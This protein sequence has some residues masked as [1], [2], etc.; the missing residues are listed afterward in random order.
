MPLRRLLNTRNGKR[1][2]IRNAEEDDIEGIVDVFESVMAEEIY[3]LG[4]HFY[5]IDFISS[6]IKSLNDLILVAEHENRVIGVLTLIREPFLKNRHVAVLGIAIKSGFRH[7]GIGSAL[8]EESIKWAKE[9]NIEKI[10]LEVFSTNTNAIELYKKFG[11]EI[12]GIRKKQFKI[13]GN[14]VDDVLMA[15]FLY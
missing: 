14:Y 7:E 8:M 6:K 15:K 4:E 2:I 9:Q 1:V 5:A 10:T 12:E 13:L 11:F 3:L